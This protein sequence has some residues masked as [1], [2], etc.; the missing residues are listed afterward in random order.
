MPLDSAPKPYRWIMLA[1]LWL[2][3][4]CFG[5]VARS[6][7]P[8]VTPILA[9]LELSYSQMGLILGSWQLTY[10]FA[11]L[12]AGTI[13]DKWGIRKSIVAGA[14]IIG[15]SA[16]LRFFSSG[17]QSMLI[18]GALFGLGGPMISIG[19]PKTISAWF[20]GR[21]RGTAMGI[22]TTG[23]WVGGLTALAL[24]NSLVMP[25][26]SQNWRLAFVV[27]GGVTFSIALL[28]LLLAR[29][30]GDGETSSVPGV[31]DVFVKLIKIKNVRILLVMGLLAFAIGHGF[32]SWLPKILEESGM[33]AASAGW[34]AAITIAAGIPSIL[35]LPTLVP[36]RF[37]GRTIAVFAIMTTVNLVLVMKVTGIALYVSL[38]TLG[39]VS[40]PFMALLLLILMDSPGVE[41]RYMGSAGGM[42]F[43]VAEIGGFTGP[44]I[45]GILVDATG[46][47]MAGAVFL[48]GLCAAMAGLTVFLT[49]P[50]VSN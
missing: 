17:F 26:V 21:S 40:A 25:L 39:F 16:S 48:A 27:Y 15:L 31:I 24:T 32:S 7:F 23:N 11:A 41:T 36:P 30:D 2:L 14:L 43:C 12:V 42:F 44:L 46:S 33:S 5:I 13:L 50:M 34:A 22:Y 4:L 47:F 45:M 19:G 49:R 1:L 29:G 3:Y 37:R 20:S 9:D 10:I 8:L 35:I 18:A 38:A 6:I 28:W